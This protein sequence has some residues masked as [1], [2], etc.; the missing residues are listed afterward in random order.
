MSIKIEEMVNKKIV[1]K[2]TLKDIT[3]DGITIVDEKEDIEETLSFDE[4]KKLIGK[5]V[6]ISFTSKEETEEY[7]SNLEES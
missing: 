7:I 4:V 1:A 6:A 5:S 2:G 3:V